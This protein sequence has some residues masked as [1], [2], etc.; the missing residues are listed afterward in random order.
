MNESSNNNPLILNNPPNNIEQNKNTSFVLT[1]KK[2]ICFLFAAFIF[3]IILIIMLNFILYRPPS[4]YSIKAIYDY[5]K[6]EITLYNSISTLKI[7]KLWIN[8]KYV[9]TN[10]TEYKC[11]SVCEVYFTIDLS[12]CT[13][14]QGMFEE[15][16]YLKSI[17]FSP[18]FKTNNIKNI[19]YLFYNCYDLESIDISNFNT[20]NVVDMRR[21]FYGSH[22]TSIDLSHFNTSNVEY[23]E[24]MFRYNDNLKSLDLS[25]LNTTSV[26][27]MTHMFYYCES[28]QSLDISSFTINDTNNNFDLLYIDYHYYDSGTITLK[29]EYKE[30]VKTIPSYWT[31]ITID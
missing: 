23:M 1:K 5:S 30:K 11:S 17:S 27:H 31:I 18:S 28:L 25:N 13:S 2:V 6:R 12:N 8:Y 9:P 29:K 22:L 4:E 20:T 14:L 3:V 24:E 16:S 21:M 19:S 26:T 15:I 10:T 7:V